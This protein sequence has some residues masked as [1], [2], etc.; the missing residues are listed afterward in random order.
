[1]IAGD[2]GRSED[3]V[4][5]PGET[6]C[7]TVAAV[8]ADCT[9]VVPA[10]NE[11]RRIGGL[12]ASLAGFGG[13]VIVVADGTDRTADLVREFGASH[14]QLALT[15]LE[16]PAR[17]GKGGGIMA[18]FRAART[19]FV[20]FMDADGSTAP[21]EMVRLFSFLGDA[22]GAIASRWA[23]GAVVPVR[24]G[25]LRRLQSRAFNLLIRLLFGLPYA[26]TQ[27]GAKVFRRE[28]LLPVLGEMELTGFEFD[29]ELLWRLSRR[30]ARVVEVPTVWYD[31]GGSKVGGGDSMP[32]LRR[33]V[34]LW[35][36]AGA[37]EPR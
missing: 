28:A 2:G 35:W 11:E 24:Q 9:I 25:P 12:L 15:C 36:A 32:M 1:M 21:A 31:H 20:G 22:D 29:V 19:P 33:L 6:A 3:G 16:F 18:G 8:P 4:R 7:G 10:Y 26:D 34:A 13:P 5:V 17:L 14:P 37:K 27:C 23:S 30:G